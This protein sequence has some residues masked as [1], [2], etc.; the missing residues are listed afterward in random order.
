LTSS[1]FVVN[2]AAANGRVG[3]EWPS[4]KS[5]IA[6]GY[7]PSFDFE[8][9]SA[10]GDAT[11]L[12]RRALGAAYDVIVSVGGDGTLNE[13]ANGFFDGDRPV[14]GDAALGVISLGTGSDFVRTLGIPRSLGSYL[15]NLGSSPAKEVDVVRG[16]FATPDGSRITRYFINCGEFGSGAA[17]ADKVNRTTKAFGG[18]MSFLWGILTTLP[19][20]KNRMITYSVDDGA[21]MKEVLNDFVVANGRYFG[22][23]L[24]PAP[25]ASLEDGLLDIVTIGDISFRE[26]LFNLGKLRNGTHLS[27]PKIRLVRGRRVVASSDEKVLVEVDGELVGR[28]PAEFEIVPKSLKLLS[29]K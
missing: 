7:S 16:R 6:A 8:L 28:L 11:R 26:V 3:K 25:E 12:T 9:T 27:N 14:G 10:P 1:F 4:I 19:G 24:K 13:V 2:P 20:Y 17:V 22:G 15:D 18:Q 21:E 5:A 29:G 23:G